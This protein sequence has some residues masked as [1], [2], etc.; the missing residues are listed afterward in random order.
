MALSKLASLA[1]DVKKHVGEHKREVAI[2]GGVLG[3]GLLLGA[4]ALR[5]QRMMR[6]AT[7]GQAELE[8]SGSAPW[9]KQHIA[10]ALVKRGAYRRM[11]DRY[12][13]LDPERAEQV[14]P[15]TLH[16][17]QNILAPDAP[18]STDNFYF[19]GFSMD[20][21]TGVWF[22]FGWRPNGVETWAMV[23][24]PEHG[25]LI[26][27]QDEKPLGP[28]GLRGTWNKPMPVVMWSRAGQD[29]SNPRVQKC[30][31]MV[32]ECI[33]PAKKWRWQYKGLLSG[34][35][36]M[37]HVDVDITWDAICPLFKADEDTDKWCTAQCM[38]REPLTP[39]F[40]ASFSRYH[41]K[42]YEGAGRAHGRVVITDQKAP[43]NGQPH[44]VIMNDLWGFRDRTFGYRDWGAFNRWNWF[45]VVFENGYLL[46]FCTIRRTNWDF[47]A[48]GWLV[49]PEGKTIPFSKA[50]SV[51]HFEQMLHG[52]VPRRFTFK[53]QLVG[54]N[55]PRECECIPNAELTMTIQGGATD[56]YSTGL[57]SY[58][59]CVAQ[60]TAV[61]DGKRVRGIGKS[62]WGMRAV[63]YSAPFN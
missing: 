22:R 4:G 62:E 44:E 25:P 57:C 13:V 33:E 63:D 26:L 6:S 32:L 19:N 60:F 61:F 7:R 11:D 39:E 34:V 58:A 53:Y 54:E 41:Q 49:T 48:N 17:E 5:F 52:T 9:L 29:L 40:F 56:K 37:V 45:G 3:A 1:E 10:Y 21:Q 23:F 15:E 20:G 31:P 50:T 51:E 18:P 36:R 12:G 42:H 27:T 59:E 8:P 28:E 35:E 43:F 38:A 55:E 24:T 47:F 14:Q 30:G 2:A 16:P 46:D